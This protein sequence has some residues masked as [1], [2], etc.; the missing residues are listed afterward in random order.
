MDVNEAFVAR[1]RE[2]ADGSGRGEQITVHHSADERVPLPDGSVD[3]VYA[4]NVL[5]Y[6]PDLDAVLAELRRA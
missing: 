4:K 5:E 1:A 2:V 6:V 3:R